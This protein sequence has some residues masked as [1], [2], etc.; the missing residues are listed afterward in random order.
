M[1]YSKAS[2]EVVIF[3]NKDVIAT[4]GGENVWPPIPICPGGE[5]GP[6]IMF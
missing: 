4:S 3:E 6:E 5:D 2:A 1:E